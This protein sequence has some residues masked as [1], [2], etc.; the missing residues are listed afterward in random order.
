MLSV[1]VNAR[2]RA[3]CEAH[4]PSSGCDSAE[5]Q[6][7]LVDAAPAVKG[8]EPRCGAYHADIESA[9]TTLRGA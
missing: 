7:K 5:V 3:A 1:S 2:Y 9:R 8:A 6:G 4:G